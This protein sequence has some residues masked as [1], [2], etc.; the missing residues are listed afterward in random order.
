MS[1]VHTGFLGVAYFESEVGWGSS[2][3]V[4]GDLKVKSRKSPVKNWKNLCICFSD[5]W[6][7]IRSYFYPSKTSK[8]QLKVKIEKRQF[9]IWKML[10]PGFFGSL[11]SNPGLAGLS[12]IGFKV[13]CRSNYER[14]FVF[15]WSC[16]VR[17]TCNFNIE[18]YLGGYCHLIS[19]HIRSN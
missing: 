15:F 17:I 13:I 1:R 11:S 3:H 12:Y 4:Q 8:G 5:C 16:L 7:W 6:V 14:N 18:K 9:K 10:T 2:R 19:G